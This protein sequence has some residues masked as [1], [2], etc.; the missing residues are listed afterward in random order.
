MTA[1]RLGAMLAAVYG[2]RVA[3]PDA[4]PAGHHHECEE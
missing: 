1:D 3:F 2:G 4:A